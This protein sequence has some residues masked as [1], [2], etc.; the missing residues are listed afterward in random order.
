MEEI[1]CSPVEKFNDVLMMFICLNTDQNVVQNQRESPLESW[2][3]DCR[4]MTCW[5]SDKFWW[6]VEWINVNVNNF[7]GDS[8]WKVQLLQRWMSLYKGFVRDFVRSGWLKRMT[9]V[10]SGPCPFF[11]HD[12]WIK[13]K[14][15]LSKQ[16]GALLITV[17][18]H[19]S[20]LFKAGVSYN[21]LQETKEAEPPCLCPQQWVTLLPLHTTTFLVACGR[22]QKLPGGIESEWIWHAFRS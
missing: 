21:L 15:C 18:F 20:A 4:N 9:W 8:W 7:R 14:S 16:P 3:I 19:W 5:S 11:W 2:W 6:R 10:I 22:P 12:L 13:V 17:I 1:R